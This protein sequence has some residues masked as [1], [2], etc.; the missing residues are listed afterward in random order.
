MYKS[1]GQ[2]ILTFLGQDTDT[3]WQS[4]SGT[5]AVWKKNVFILNYFIVVYELSILLLFNKHSKL[6]I[7]IYIYFFFPVALR[8]DAG[9]GFLILE[10]STPYSVGLLWTSDQPVAQTYTLQHT[11]LTKDKYPCPRRDSN[12][13]SLQPR[14]AV[15]PRL[16]PRGHWNGQQTGYWVHNSSINTRLIICFPVGT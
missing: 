6:Y 11:T 3:A 15:D 4:A 14:L 16:R 7:Y 5:T 9:H 1:V 8:P 12:P 10:V 13:Q 2:E